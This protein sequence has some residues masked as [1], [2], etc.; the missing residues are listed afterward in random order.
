MILISTM[1]S[2]FI[3]LTIL[4]DVVSVWKVRKEFTKEFKDYRVRIRAICYLGCKAIYYTLI[5]ISYILLSPLVCF[6]TLF[7]YILYQLFAMG[8]LSN[9]IKELGLIAILRALTIP[10]IIIIIYLL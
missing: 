5:I 4:D 9:I 3:V 1:F 10:L 2:L 6:L 8:L 7:V